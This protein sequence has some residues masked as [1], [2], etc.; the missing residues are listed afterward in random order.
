MDHL[1]G[2][3]NLGNTCYLNSALQIL[4]N[5]TVLSKVILSQTF[6]SDKLNI[7][8]KFLLNY[9]NSSDAISPNEIK[10]LVGEKNNKFLN[11]QQHDS[12]EFLI[13]LI[14]VIEDELKKEYQDSKTEILGIK[15]EDFMSNI[16]DTTVSSIIYSDEINEKSKTRTGEK[17]L[18]LPIPNTS[19]STLDDCINLYTK[20]EKLTGDS[21]WFSEK[22]KRKVDAYKR[23]YLKSL[24]KYLLIQLKR[25]NFFSFSNKN[26]TDVT[27][28][29]EFEIKNYK[30]ELRGIIYHMGGANGGHYISI[31]KQNDK[32]FAC[33]DN[34]VNEINNITNFL[35]K[36]YTY[37]FVKQK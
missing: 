15:L 6:R 3:N 16:F 21:Q 32:W 35:K 10:L 1:T 31:I 25:F 19:N 4:V 12:H 34:S 24:P 13:H 29:L 33:N 7:Y 30:Y 27:V 37:L 28:P 9:R 36:G 18:S 26:D 2:L 5:C 11:F 17:I 22:E 8:K 14:E 23:L 20:I